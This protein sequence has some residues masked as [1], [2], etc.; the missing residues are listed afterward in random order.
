[1]E[2]SAT[3]RAAGF[4][5]LHVG[6]AESTNVAALR[7]VELGADRLWLVA[8][9]QT[10]GRGRHGRSWDSP[11]GNLHASLGLVAPCAPD[12]APRLGFVAGLSLAEAVL[13]LVPELDGRLRL[14]W[15]NDGL[16]DSV[17][18]AGLLAE[19]TRL[20]EDRMG[21]AIG[22]GVNV[23]KAPD[24]LGHD[25]TALA[26]HAAGITRDAL[27]V[28]LADRIAANLSCFGDGDGFGVIRENWLRHALPIGAPVRVRLPSGDRDGAFGGIDGD[29]HLLLTTST[30]TERILAGDVFPLAPD[31]IARRFA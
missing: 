20:G 15:P 12:I 8:D 11:R 29:G 17:K 24:G 1:M 30:G 2:L 3:A 26:A 18:F 25:V 10:A 13:A 27:F 28:A 16:I 7:A 21:M 31:E 4:E 19:G 23:A 14:K 6:S 9:R 22:I 5:L